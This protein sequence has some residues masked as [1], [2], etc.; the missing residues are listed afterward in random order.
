MQASNVTG[1][2]GASVIGDQSYC[3]TGFYSNNNSHY[4]NTNTQARFGGR[5]VSGGYGTGFGG[6]GGQ[7]SYGG[8]YANIGNTP[9]GGQGVVGQQGYGQSYGQGYDQQQQYGYGAG[10][11]YAPGQQ[12]SQY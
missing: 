11:G 2:K 5:N 8:G 1:P 4:G 10:T 9:Y 6:F 7:N 12:S 3:Q